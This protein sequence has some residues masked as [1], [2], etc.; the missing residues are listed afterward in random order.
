[1]GLVTAFSV[2]AS[3]RNTAFPSTR[4]VATRKYTPGHSLLIKGLCLLARANASNLNEQLEQEIGI[5]RGLEAF[6][7]Q[8]QLSRMAS[9]QVEHHAAQ[10][11]EVLRAISDTQTGVILTGPRENNPAPR[12]EGRKLAPPVIPRMGLA[13][14]AAS[15][16]PTRKTDRMPG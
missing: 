12:G 14:G 2:L 10:D 15:C 8:A 4:N 1:M 5:E 9:E 13:A 16:V 7:F 11:G 6:A 3:M